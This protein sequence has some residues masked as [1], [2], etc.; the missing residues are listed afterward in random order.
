MTRRVFTFE[1]GVV[2]PEG[3][4][5]VFEQWQQRKAKLSVWTVTPAQVCSQSVRKG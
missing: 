4:D 2:T 5:E 1:G 3:G